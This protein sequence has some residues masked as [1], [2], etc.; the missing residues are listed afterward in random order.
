[1]AS[2]V[3][4]KMRRPIQWLVDTWGTWAI[5]HNQNVL[6]GEAH[7][8]CSLEAL[9]VQELTFWL[10]RFVLVVR[11]EDGNCS[12]PKSL[13]QLCCGLLRQLNDCGR[14]KVNMFMLFAIS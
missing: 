4:Q 5:H 8:N 1:M 7:F 10:S 13:Y 2:G 14:P 11:R 12:L 6:P 3:P 9:L